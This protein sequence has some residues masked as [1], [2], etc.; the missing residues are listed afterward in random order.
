MGVLSH[1]RAAPVPPAGG[2]N[3]PPESD[4]LLLTRRLRW[5]T[6]FRVL[7][8]TL[9][10]GSATLFS[11]KAQ[12]EG[13]DSSPDDL[14]YLAI[15]V[16]Y[17]LSFVYLAI[18]TGLRSVRWLRLFAYIQ[19]ST[20]ALLSAVL[21][22]VTGGTDSVFSFFFSL[23]II[24]AAII[25]HR[26]GAFVLAGMSAFALVAFAL[27]ELDVWHWLAPLSPITTDAGSL[28]I[29]ATRLLQ[30]RVYNVG[31]NTFAF[32]AVAG[33]ASVLSEQVRRSAREY[34]ETRSSLEELKALHRNIVNSVM[35]GLITVTNEG[36]I[37][38]F[39]RVAESATGMT[40]DEVL[41]R[42]I[43]SVFPNLEF[44]TSNVTEVAQYPANR[45]TREVVGGR[46]V[47]L[48]WSISP[49]FNAQQRTVGHVLFVRDI[50][51]LL[52]M[53]SRMKR[54][55]QLAAIGEL[56][57]RVAHEIRNPLASIS[58]SVELLSRQPTTTAL[59]ARLMGIVR[60]EVESLNSWIGDFLD[61]SREVR[62]EFRPVRA[63]AV[64]QE[65]LEAF[66]QEAHGVRLDLDYGVDPAD[67]VVRA[68]PQR[69]KQVIWNLLRNAVEAQEDAVHPS[70]SARNSDAPRIA[71][72]I[73]RT[74]DRQSLVISVRD[75]GCG[76]TEETARQVFEPFFT[77]KPK[78]TGLGLATS[79]RLVDAHG[80]HLKITSTL[81]HGATFLIVL[82]LS[83]LEDGDLE[84]A[85]DSRAV[86]RRS[87]TY[88]AGD[89]SAA[90]FQSE[91]V[92]LSAATDE[93]QS[94][95]QGPDAPILP[96]STA[97]A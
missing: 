6:L 9:L 47:H 79:Y 16:T 5:L 71:V 69:L 94:A 48:R 33:L 68:D 11:L 2:A 96:G 55:E 43:D 24:N 60:R 59:A 52:A 25:V 7:L 28:P 64:V 20:D 35:S 4:S 74:E 36:R 32:F 46:E 14:L 86:L 58:T 50:T 49:L 38:F 19:L 62:L 87:G 10:L 61:Y 80:G 67:T 8:V 1:R 15:G 51:D 84:P 70:A 13:H 18:L 30:T 95:A 3:L 85:P 56:A 63:S 27:G 17:G 53:E 12:Q 39:N 97:N 29:D 88:R 91:R 34:E 77:T 81:G 93:A 26:S 72:R 45:A 44:S 22:F 92:G 37:T 76:M 83:K 31:V 41:G 89:T 21:V 65:T 57:A 40:E 73:D 23:T 42:P 90:G 82:P 66:R 78:G 54:A 75:W